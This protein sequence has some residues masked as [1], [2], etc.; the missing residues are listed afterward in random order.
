MDLLCFEK[1]REGDFVRGGCQYQYNLYFTLEDDEEVMIIE[2]ILKTLR[3][4]KYFFTKQQEVKK[5]LIVVL[6][7][8]TERRALEYSKSLIRKLKEEKSKKTKEGE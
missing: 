5:E 1:F 7:K 2:K 4:I 8:T 3:N 6:P